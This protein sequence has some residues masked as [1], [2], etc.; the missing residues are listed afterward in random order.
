MSLWSHFRCFCRFDIVFNVFT[1]VFCLIVVLFLSLV[2][3]PFTNPS[4]MQI[5]K[6]SYHFLY[7]MALRQT[8]QISE[9]HVPSLATPLKKSPSWLLV[10]LSLKRKPKWQRDRPLRWN[11]LNPDQRTKNSYDRAHTLPAT[12]IHILLHTHINAHTLGG[13]DRQMGLKKTCLSLFCHLFTWGRPNTAC[14]FATAVSFLL[15]HWC[16]SNLTNIYSPQHAGAT[17]A[18]CIT[19]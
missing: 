18:C 11:Q 3:C 13:W 16:N 14:L 7:R 1:V 5:S 6:P 19:T 2:T 8:N 17:A 12:L 4:M 10:F 15:R 9:G